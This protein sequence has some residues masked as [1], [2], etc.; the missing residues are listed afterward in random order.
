[1]DIPC[2]VC[3]LTYNS[4]RTLA[5]TLESVKDFADVVVVD[6]GSTDATLTIARQYGA[7]IFPQK[8]DGAT[9][10]ITDFTAV[11]ARSFSLAREP[12]RLWLDSDEWLSEESRQ[13]VRQIADRGDTSNLYAFSRRAVI[14]NRVIEYAYFYPEYCKRL[15]HRESDV[16]LKKGKKV[17]EDLVVG[18]RATVKKIPAVIFHE[19]RER[20]CDLVEKDRRYLALTVLGK[21][22]FPF[23]KKLRVAFVNVLKGV[24]VILASVG[25]YIR[26]GFRRSL[27][28]LHAW[29]FARYHFLYAKKIL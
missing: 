5:R 9:G 1:M 13:A 26:H 25:I 4:D 6:G 3:I 2:S 17:H 10:P 7:R 16:Y 28:P 27:P 23:Q 14:G 24:R 22:H 29:R 20:Y 15:F 8:E 11:R 21:E 12:W 18:S 19:W